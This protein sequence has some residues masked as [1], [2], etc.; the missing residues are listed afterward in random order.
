MVGNKYGRALKG[1]PK[2]EEWKREASAAKMG[3][4]NPMRNPVYARRMAES[5]RGKPNPKH[6]EFWRLHKDEQLRK[7]MV[8][9]HK[10][11]N[12]LELKLIDLIGRN[13]LQF[14]YVGNWE[15]ILGGKCPDFVSMGGKKQII[16]LFGNYWHTTK[17]RESADERIAHFK[18]FGFDTLILWERDLDNEDQ[19]LQKILQFEHESRPLATLST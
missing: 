6:K 13:H 2:S 7:M 15:F 4:R 14:R 19:T 11:P 9:L 1:R 16:E 3:D 8:G 12:R 10:K 17:S 18:R 5:K